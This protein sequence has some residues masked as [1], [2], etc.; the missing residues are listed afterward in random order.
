MLRLTR[1]PSH[2]AKRGYTALRRRVGCT[3]H[4]ATLLHTLRH[5]E[6]G[7]TRGVHR[8]DAEGLTAEAFAREFLKLPPAARRPC[9]IRGLQL[10]QVDGWT[11]E[12]FRRDFGEAELWD[13]ER[14]ATRRVN[15]FF[16]EDPATGGGA[17]EESYLFQ[18]LGPEC[19]PA[20][21]AHVE[22]MRS[23]FTVPESVFGPD[24]WKLSA[25]A[26][27]HHDRVV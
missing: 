27:P 4:N 13:K 19:G 10:G 25:C 8:I 20:P 26:P 14:L 7:S 22:R 17:T 16:D 11:I 9:V 21:T 1:R 23:S 24:V 6:N 2:H 5:R 12:S 18:S 15:E 3:Q